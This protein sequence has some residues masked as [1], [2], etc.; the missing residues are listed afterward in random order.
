MKNRKGI[1][2]FLCFTILL[3]VVMINA[4]NQSIFIY[5]PSGNYYQSLQARIPYFFQGNVARVNSLDSAIMNYNAGFLLEPPILNQTQTNILKNYLNHA[6]RFYLFAS[7]LGGSIDLLTFLGFE[8]IHGLPAGTCVDTTVGLS[9][10][11][12]EGLRIYQPISYLSEFLSVTGTVI[13]ILQARCPTAFNHYSAF[14]TVSD[15]FKAVVDIYNYTYN[16]EFL[17]RLL[18]YFDLDVIPVEL[19][20]FEAEA[21][22]GK[23]ILK[24]ITAT[25]T[26]N[27]EFQ[28]EKKKAEN[29]WLNIGFVLGYG[30]T[31]EPKNYSFNDNEVSNGKYEYRLKQIDFDG[32]Y[33]YSQTIKVIVDLP[34]YFVLYQ[35]YPNPFNSSSVIKYS[36]PQSSNVVIKVFDILGNEIETLVNEEKSV[37]TYEVTWNATN[38]PSGVYLARIEANSS[39]GKTESK[40]IKIVVVK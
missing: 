30:T 25:E 17:K 31:T 33:E 26:N 21:Y 3:P 8:Q 22:E 23:I 4:Q 38:L 32:S 27:M 15:T 29:E 24:W 34:H 39:S 18:S 36:L 14:A 20:N 2:A 7:G 37:G 9:G 1:I 35:N 19:T 6:G 16:G 5:D 40:V 10:T 12:T 11:F 13:P 28:I